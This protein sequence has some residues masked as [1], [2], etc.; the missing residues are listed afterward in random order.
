LLDR[1]RVRRFTCPKL[2]ARIVPGRELHA[3]DG[4]ARD[5]SGTVRWVS[6][7]A[8]FTPSSR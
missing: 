8:S 2:R 1:P 5:F 7:D 6:A 4:E 3:I